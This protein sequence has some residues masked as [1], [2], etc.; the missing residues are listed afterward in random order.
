MNFLVIDTE[1]TTHNHGNPF[2]TRNFNVCISYTNGIERGVVFEERADFERLFRESSLI[3]GFNLKYDLHWLRRLG[4]SI[5]G[6][7]FWCCQAGAFVLGRQDTPYPSLDGECE[8]H[9]LG[10]KL[11]VIEEE[12]WSK[13]INTHEIPRGILSEYALQD[14]ELTLKLYLKQQALIQPYQRTLLSLTMQDLAVL[15]E[16]EWNGLHFDKEESLK[17]AKIIET[18]IHELQTKLNLFHNIPT[19]NWA[20]NDHLSA[21][22][23]GGTITEKQRLPVGVY[24]TG[25]KKGLPRF[26]V[27]LVTY[28]LPR[29]YTPIRGSESKKGGTWSVDESYLKKL[30]AKNQELIDG[31]LRIKELQ[32]LNSTYFKGIPSLHE[33]MYWGD[34][35]IHGQYNQCVARTGR[36]SSSRPN[37]QNI[38]EI[39]QEIFTTRYDD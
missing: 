21:L 27:E 4:F 5:Q 23:Y 3:I 33:Q 2:D 30:K 34:N 7:R 29:I 32:K 13:G 22:L 37:Q 17:K 16:M 28:R 18:E 15:Q 10:K 9:G 39:A 20:S 6:K 12:Y 11:S 38:S 8:R 24:K 26:K 14:V 25:D 36:L 19:F 35:I 1:N 31:I